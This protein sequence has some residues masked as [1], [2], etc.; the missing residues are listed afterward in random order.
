LIYPS[1]SSTIMGFFRCTTVGSNVYLTFDFNHKCF[2]SKWYETLPIAIIL[3]IIYPI[4]IP[5]TEFIILYWIK[6]GMQSI[7]KTRKVKKYVHLWNRIGFLH[8]AYSSNL[9]WFEVIDTFHKFFLT[10]CMF[11]FP[12]YQIQIGLLVATL[13][14][15]FIIV[16]FPY[17][18][19]IDNRMNLLVQGDILLFLLLALIL[20]KEKG[21]YDTY[22]EIIIII[23]TFIIFSCIALM[24]LYNI[25]LIM[26]K[27][28]LVHKR[29]KSSVA[30]TV[31][32]D[33]I[34]ESTAGYQTFGREK[35]Q[36]KHTVW[37][38]NQAN[39]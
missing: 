30:R 21:V 28:V 35:R 8:F 15:V 10:S 19:E 18:R 24:L 36:D 27:A 26:K 31:L 14:Y 25:L 34:R 20:L 32:E 29:K 2:D 13:H 12:Y 5:I 1:V 23:F 4:G 39:C 22:M 3:I 7:T 33:R 38:R 37:S 6:N 9:Y 16:A 17:V 11:L